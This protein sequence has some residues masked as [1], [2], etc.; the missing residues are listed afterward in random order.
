MGIRSW[1]LFVGLPGIPL[2]LG[3]SV[4]TGSPLTQVDEF[5]T[6]R[7]ERPIGIVGAPPYCGV[8]LWAMRLAS[9]LGVGGHH[10][11]QKVSSKLTSSTLV[12]RC[13]PIAVVKRTLSAYLLALISGTQSQLRSSRM[14]SIC[15]N[16]PA[17]VC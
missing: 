6:F 4:R 17:M 7:T 16:L 15:A 8:T 5:A 3:N 2:Y 12:R 9:L 10:K 1:L 11:L 14:R 13:V